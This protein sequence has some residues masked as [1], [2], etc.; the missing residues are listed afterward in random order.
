V[1]SKR[2][3]HAGINMVRKVLMKV[4]QDA[5]MKVKQITATKKKRDALTKV[6]TMT[7]GKGSIPTFFYAT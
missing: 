4:K 1:D 5:L 3:I 7:L 6:G 2:N